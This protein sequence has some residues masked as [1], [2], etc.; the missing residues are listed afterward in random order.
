MKVCDI[1]Q[2]WSP[3]SGGVKR[4]VS[5]KVRRLQEQGGRHVLIIPGAEDAVSGDDSARVYTIRSPYLSRV[6][7]YRVLLRLGEIGRILA[8]EKPDVIE[9]GD[10]YQVGHYTA[11]KG[12]ELGI[13]TAA[14][15]HSHVAESY[16]RP[17]EKWVGSTLADLLVDGARKYTASLYNR[18]SATIIPA[19]SLV[20]TLGDWGV[21][22]TRLQRLGMD[23]ECFRPDGEGD[24]FRKK[25]GI[26]AAPFVFLYVG[27]LAAEKNT[28][29]LWEAF[30]LVAAKQ[31][32]RFHLVV[33]G[34][35]LQRPEVDRLKTETGA[36]TW[37]PYCADSRDL[38]E[39]Y[40]AADVFV[41]PG[42]EETFGLVALEAQ[43]CGRF[44]LGFQ[45]ARLEAT[46]FVSR[47]DWAEENTAESLAAAMLRVAEKTDLN[48]E[49][50]RLSALVHQYYDWRQ[51]L[52]RLFDIYRELIHHSRQP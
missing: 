27:R 51:V 20:K 8:A 38:A 30:R 29:M 12:R 13:P 19:K 40:R 37:L 21:S 35:G 26:P 14:F 43:A 33:V 48:T 52:D 31:L 42:I 44:V 49:G 7:E 23:G 2:F 9:C 1:T 18:F 6:T 16:I 3:T 24:G 28:K 17:L 45:K 11:R 50:L 36:V 46:E 32:G 15:Y 34:D 5:E 10:P 41:H 25:H 39:I 4:Y 47:E 22:N